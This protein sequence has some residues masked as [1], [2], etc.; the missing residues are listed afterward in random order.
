MKDTKYNLI[1]FGRISTL[2]EFNIKA[3]DFHG[4]LQ[5]KSVSFKY[6]FSPM[7]S[8]AKMTNSILIILII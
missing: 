8:P 1:K 6:K 3:C 4:V 2:I 7:V 5:E